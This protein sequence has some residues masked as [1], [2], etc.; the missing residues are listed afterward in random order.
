MHLTK[1]KDRLPAP[2]SR[3]MKD[4]GE[5]VAPC[6]FARAG[7]MKY[8]AK[9]LSPLFDDLPPNQVVRVMR[10]KDELYKDSVIEALKSAPITIGHPD[11]DVSVDNYKDLAK[12]VLSGLPLKD[13]DST[14]EAS[15]SGELVLFDKDAI[16]LSENELDGLSLGYTAKLIRVKDGKD[17]DAEQVDIRP[18][19]IAMV[20]LGRAGSE[21][22]IGDSDEVAKLEE[23]ELKAKKLAD[24]ATAFLESVTTKLADAETKIAELE[25]KLDAANETIKSKS[26]LRFSDE[27]I[28]EMVAKRTQFLLNAKRLSDE[29]FSKVT[30]EEAMRSIVTKRIGDVSEKSLA[31]VQARF[32]ILLEDEAPSELA[33][34]MG[35]QLKDANFAKVE[36][37]E[38]KSEE[39]RRRMVERHMHKNG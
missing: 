34:I 39:A 17:W 13:T 28:L 32:E 30:E 26:S 37:T 12:G 23:E 18:N 6:T 14:G 27:D 15:L 7:V 20:K 1:F 22:R 8:L 16:K 4:S 36:K 2:T 19:H 9:E 10:H 11:E 25:A 29:D 35:K 38:S 5:M 24:E 3:V 31:Y 21:F 33:E